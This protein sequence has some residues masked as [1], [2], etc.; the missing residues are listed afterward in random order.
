MIPHLEHSCAAALPEL[1]Q[2]WEAASVPEP[3]LLALDEGLA[4]E[5]G[6]DPVWL[7]SPEG[8]RFLVGGSDDPALPRPVA[9]AYAGHQFGHYSPLLGDGRAL[10]LGETTTTDGR[11]VDVHLK[12]SGRTPYARGGD[13]LA[14]VG[15]MLREHLMGVFAH[16]VGLPTT[17]SLGV[18]GTGGVVHR[19][20]PLP[21][22]VLVRVA[23]SHL[24]VGTVQ[25]AAASHGR[26]VLERLVHH[27]LWRHHAERAE[28]GASAG[29]PE[30]L[31]LLRAVCEAQARTVAQWMGLGVVH[32]VMNTDNM[33]LSGETI[34]YGPVAMLDAHDP[35]AV[36]SSIDHAGRYAYGN[37]PAAA[38]WNLARLAE[39]LL[40][41]VD[42]DPERA[43]DRAT[44]VLGDFAECYRA[45]HTALFSAKLGL[46]EPDEQRVGDFLLRL[47][48]EGGDHTGTFDRLT[49]EAA[50]AGETERA[51]RMRAVNP[52]VV[53]RNHVVEQTLTA[54]TAGDL[55]PVHAVAAALADPF[56]TPAD[57]APEVQALLAPSP[58]GSPRHVTF[59]GT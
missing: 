52:V 10:L 24:R 19:E 45:E 58:V 33:T 25:H 22:A 8:V 16:A 7:R 1:S 47:A 26:E 21:G 34:D 6:W 28:V 17:R 54:A 49:R 12:G 18:V 43:V 27:A 42:E 5:L 38:Q 48:A 9:Q 32:G 40:P 57:T 59:C 31:T 20:E 37:Q 23:A 36:F 41:L 46:T 56:S 29:E 2:P 4:A 13:G 30:A 53:P 44:T 50:A 11:R 14:A 35:Q 3:T 51:A 15:P 39:A 55:G